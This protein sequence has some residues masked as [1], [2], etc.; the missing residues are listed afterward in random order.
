MILFEDI[1]IS[2]DILSEKF[3]C[4]LDKCKGACCVQGDTGAP[5]SIEECCILDDIYLLIKPFMTPEGIEAVETNGKYFFF[6]SDEP[7]TALVNN[8]QCVYAVFDNNGIA[9]C[10]IENAFNQGIVNFRKPAS[11]YLYPVRVSQTHN[12]TALNYHQWDI[13]CDAVSMGKQKNVSVL[14][15][16]EKP[17]RENFGDDMFETLSQIKL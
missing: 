1:I 16:L 9:R 3:V 5:L 13:C 15:F 17:L 11:C 6:T 2:D 8:Q 12:H 14:K 4:D 7:V 10:A